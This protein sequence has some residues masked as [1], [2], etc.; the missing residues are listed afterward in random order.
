MEEKELQEILTKAAEKNGEAIKDAVKNAMD[1]AIKGFITTDQLATKLNE[2]GVTD[3]SIK[4]LTTAVE[5]QGIE[6]G[7]LV[8]GKTEKF[9]S[10]KDLVQKQITD[11]AQAIKELAE[12]NN[13]TVKFKVDKTIKTYYYK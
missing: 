13:G 2:F 1:S 5:K 8:S 9:E 6:L 4:D 12:S 3:K 7:K 11:N 10:V